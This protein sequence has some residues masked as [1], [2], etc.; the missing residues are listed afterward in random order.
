MYCYIFIYIIYNI[1]LY[2]F[3]SEVVFSYKICVVYGLFV[4]IYSSNKFV[5]NLG[6]TIFVFKYTFPC[7]SFVK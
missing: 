3:N 6:N 5:Q 4:A 7:N 1:S 2:Y